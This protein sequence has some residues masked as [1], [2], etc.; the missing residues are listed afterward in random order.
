MNFETY[1]RCLTVIRYIPNFGILLTYWSPGSRSLMTEIPLLFNLVL[2]CAFPFLFP[3][4][5]LNTMRA[6]LSWLRGT[7]VGWRCFKPDGKFQYSLEIL[8]LSKIHALSMASLHKWYT[9]HWFQQPAAD[10]W[11][12]RMASKMFLP[13]LYPEHG[14]ANSNHLK[15][16]AK[17]GWIF[18][19]W[20]FNNRMFI[21]INHRRRMVPLSLWWLRCTWLTANLRFIVTRIWFYGSSSNHRRDRRY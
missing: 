18:K 7:D 16:T 15:A 12:S 2:H 17:S 3:C 20:N 4:R 19:R 14:I 5:P 8:A 10:L 9:S 6:T 13:K 21:R 11:M 1:L